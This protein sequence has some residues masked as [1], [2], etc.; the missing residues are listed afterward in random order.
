M[1]PPLTDPFVGRN[2]KAATCLQARSSYSCTNLG[3]YRKPEEDLAKKV[4]SLRRLPSSS[5]AAHTCSENSPHQSELMITANNSIPP[6]SQSRP[7]ATQIDETQRLSHR[8][9]LLWD[10][11]R[12]LHLLGIKRNLPPCPLC[13][14]HVFET[15]LISFPERLRRMLFWTRSC[16]HR[17]LRTCLLSS[18]PPSP[19]LLV[20][21]QCSQMLSLL[22]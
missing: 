14:W 4:E 2:K 5:H 3:K 6:S 16:V 10:S 15:K 22:V 12:R 8:A 21:T 13:S 18:Q 7:Q 11:C 17:N 20:I 19:P 1:R 9:L